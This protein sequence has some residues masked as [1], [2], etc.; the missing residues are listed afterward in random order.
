[1]IAMKNVLVAT[2]FGEAADTA[3]TYGRELAQRFDATLH[4]LHVAENVYIT[5]FGA[6]TYASF[7]PDLQ[8]DIEENKFPQDFSFTDYHRYEFANLMRMTRMWGW[9]RR[10]TSSEFMTEAHPGSAKLWDPVTYGGPRMSS[11]WRCGTEG[12]TQSR[13]GARRLR[14]V[15]RRAQHRHRPTCSQAWAVPRPGSRRPA[16]AHCNAGSDSAPQG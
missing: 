8:R 12:R 13:A 15:H 2:D 6:E 10:D 1:M 7:A 9:T 14:W 5:A 16:T 3:L 11:A 4:V